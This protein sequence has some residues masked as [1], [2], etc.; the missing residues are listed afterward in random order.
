MPSILTS[1]G[2]LDGVLMP[3]SGPFQRLGS[4]NAGL[5]TASTPA[6]SIADVKN[7]T[8]YVSSDEDLQNLVTAFSAQD[9]Q[10]LHIAVDGIGESTPSLLVA[11]AE[12]RI[13]DEVSLGDRNAAERGDLNNITSQK[14]IIATG[15]NMNR[16]GTWTSPTGA[17]VSTLPTSLG[18]TVSFGSDNTSG[19]AVEYY[20][21]YGAT[22]LGDYTISR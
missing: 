1:G 2:G 12:Y 8:I 21:Q 9:R 19:R 16:N 22:D 13:G 4:M 11:P 15:W 14:E 10:N 17:I 5:C 3:G 7:D 6:A 18:Q 20:A